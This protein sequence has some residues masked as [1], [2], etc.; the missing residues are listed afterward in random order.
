MAEDWE[1]EKYGGIT[2]YWD[3]T[4]RQVHLSMPE[5]VK[6]SLIRFQHTLQ[7]LT[8]QPHKHT[9]P[10][11]GATIQYAKAAYTPN[12]LNDANKAFVQQVN[13][14]FLYYA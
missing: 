6:D 4:K 7:K 12:K 2:I 1:G 3:Y 13:G 14:T 9:I 8:D 10:V 11:F 5:Y